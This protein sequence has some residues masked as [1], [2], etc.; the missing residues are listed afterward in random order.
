MTSSPSSHFFVT[1]RPPFGHLSITSIQ[2]NSTQNNH[3][4]TDQ[5]INYGRDQVV[6]GNVVNIGR[7][8]VKQFTTTVSNF[9]S[10]HKS[11]WDALAGIG[12]SDNAEQQFFRGD[13]LE[14]TQEDALRI[15]RE[16]MLAKGHHFPICWLS[17]AAGVGKSAIA[18]TVAKACEEEGLLTSFFFF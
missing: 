5:N 10:A 11:L 9:F 6:G 1:S 2:T 7:D 8:F 12:A 14:G 15:I 3:N 18:M 16:W 13:C 17:G 4:A